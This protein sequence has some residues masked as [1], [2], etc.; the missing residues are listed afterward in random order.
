[1]G[2]GIGR[3]GAV[4]GGAVACTSS[5]LHLLRRFNNRLEQNKHKVFKDNT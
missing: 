2:G 1:M 3:G 4:L 5:D